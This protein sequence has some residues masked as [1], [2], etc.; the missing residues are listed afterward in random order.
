MKIVVLDQAAELSGKVDFIKAL[1]RVQFVASML[2]LCLAYLIIVPLLLFFIDIWDVWELIWKET[3]VIAA[4]FTPMFYISFKLYRIVAFGQMAGS[5]LIRVVAYGLFVLFIINTG[6]WAT[7]EVSFIP[8]VLTLPSFILLFSFLRCLEDILLPHDQITRSALGWERA[9]FSPVNQFFKEVLGVNPHIVNSHIFPPILLGLGATV[10]ELIGI[11][12]A[13]N[14]LARMREDVSSL[15]LAVVIFAVIFQF[16]ICRGA[17]VV[18]RRLRRWARKCAVLGY[19][20]LRRHDERHPVLYLRSFKDDHGSLVAAKV[21][22]WVRYFNPNGRLGTFE[23]VAIWEA[24]RIGPMI[25]LGNPRDHKL[26]I[27]AARVYT[28]DISWQDL[29]RRLCADAAIILITLQDTDSI[30]WEIGHLKQEN[31]LNKTAIFF[32]PE[33]HAILWKRLET[34]IGVTMSEHRPINST[35]L[36]VA[37]LFDNL[38]PLLLVTTHY[39]EPVYTTAI[40]VALDHVTREQ[41]RSEVDL[42]DGITVRPELIGAL[43]NQGQHRRSGGV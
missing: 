43:A 4:I 9:F 6:Y 14:P 12:S 31:F 7:T 38:Q 1:V 15:S 10:F 30:F 2:L 16:M 35:L 42:G 39:T 19:E 33:A 40:R 20:R 22:W 21:P 41:D 25:A 26:P 8:I 11:S 3:L 17:F 29:V 32:P 37:L 28:D 34:L 18:A 24:S 13:L 27:G 5:E 23:E 36:P